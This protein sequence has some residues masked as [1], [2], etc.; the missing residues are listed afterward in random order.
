MFESYDDKIKGG[1]MLF[2]N[3]SSNVIWSATFVAF[4]VF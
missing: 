2:V 1:S 3:N 4:K